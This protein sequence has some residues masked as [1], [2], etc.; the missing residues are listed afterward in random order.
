MSYTQHDDLIVHYFIYDDVWPRRKNQLSGVRGQPNTAAPGKLREL[1]DGFVNG[2]C[3]VQRSVWRLSADP[4]DDLS[5]V[6]SRF[7]C[8]AES[9]QVR[10]IFSMRSTTS[11]CS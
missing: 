8:P 6:V 5:K 4:L 1:G 3:D 9:H 11:S 7:G 10:N 2:A